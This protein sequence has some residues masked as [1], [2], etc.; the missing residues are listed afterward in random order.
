MDYIK[1][2]LEH[3]RAFLMNLRC[4]AIACTCLSEAK[5][6]TEQTWIEL[7][8]ERA[9]EDVNNF[10]D[11]EVEKHIADIENHHITKGGILKV[12]K[13]EQT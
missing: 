1:L 7:I 11:T 9:L 12:K 8:S 4:L 6:G 2:D 10:S 13:D 3:K 5:G